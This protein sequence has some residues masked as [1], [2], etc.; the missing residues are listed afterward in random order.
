MVTRGNYIERHKQVFFLG[1]LLVLMMGAILFSGESQRMFTRVLLLQNMLF[2]AVV[3]VKKS[4]WVRRI[5]YIFIG[6]IIIRISVSVLTNSAWIDRAGEVVF[7]G[8]FIVITIIILSDLYG[9][10]EMSIE[11]VYTVFSGFILLCF[12]FGFILMSLNN[13]FPNAINGI[14]QGAEVSSYIYFSFITML[15]IGYGD[16]TPATDLAKQIVV[17]GAL[18]GHFYTVF[19]TALIIGKIF[20]N[21]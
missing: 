7:M 10:K 14:S 18:A 17:F 11:S 2:G 4:T 19:I 6:L 9:R 5:I 20:N 21:T 16:M 1:S 3:S 15:T 8:Y 13:N 12:A